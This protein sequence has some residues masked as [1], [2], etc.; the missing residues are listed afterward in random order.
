MNQKIAEWLFIKRYVVNKLWFKLLC[1]AI[2]VFGVLGTVVLFSGWGIFYWFGL[3]VGSV[4]VGLDVYVIQADMKLAELKW[5]AAVT[6]R[7]WRMIDRKFYHCALIA[8]S[9][10]DNLFY[11]TQL[12][13]TEMATSEAVG[14]KLR[15]KKGL[16][17]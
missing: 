17:K 13:P 8:W 1:L 10:P 2:D 11:K 5:R 16:R 9:I 3:L 4:F 15:A 14:R 7:L 6:Y 12:T